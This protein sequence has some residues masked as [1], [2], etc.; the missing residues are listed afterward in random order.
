M[1]TDECTDHKVNE[2]ATSIRVEDDPQKEYT[3]R[4]V[5]YQ[6]GIEVAESAQFGAVNGL[7]DAGK[8]AQFGG[9]EGNTT[10]AMNTLYSF[11]CSNNVRVVCIITGDSGHTDSA[12]FSL[13]IRIFIYSNY[14]VI[15]LFTHIIK[16][17]SCQLTDL[18]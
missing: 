13:I 12:L 7:H 17:F 16:L 10:S 2:G 18:M 4:L 6:E 15:Q 8:S 5:L 14:I 9:D 1:E 3:Y 11:A